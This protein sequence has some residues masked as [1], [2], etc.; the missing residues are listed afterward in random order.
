M[1]HA[2]G[3]KAVVAIQAPMGI[4]KTE[5]VKALT[6]ANVGGWSNLQIPTYRATLSITYAEKF[7]IPSMSGL[8]MR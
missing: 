3:S 5:A 1:A 2:H 4:G 8:V 6:A 7:R